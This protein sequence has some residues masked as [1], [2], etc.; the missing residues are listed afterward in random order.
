MLLVMLRMPSLAR[1]SGL[2]VTDWGSVGHLRDNCGAGG[3]G[4]IEACQIR[5]GLYV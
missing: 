4:K 1:V 5:V 3:M 2:W